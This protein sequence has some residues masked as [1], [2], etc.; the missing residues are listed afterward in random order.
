V[1]NKGHTLYKKNSKLVLHAID[2]E[3][4][5]IY[6]EFSTDTSPMHQESL[7]DEDP[8][9]YDCKVKWVFMPKSSEAITTAAVDDVFL[10]VL[11]LME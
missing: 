3:P 11:L 9:D 7:M 2:E 5:K 1:I 6:S 4:D 8:D 10:T